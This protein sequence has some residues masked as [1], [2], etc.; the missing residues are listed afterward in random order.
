M[1]VRHGQ[2]VTLG[3]A[4]KKDDNVCVPRI[5]P[6]D[7][8]QKGGKRELGWFLRRAKGVNWPLEFVA[9]PN[10]LSPKGAMTA[11]YLPKG[12]VTR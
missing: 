7:W 12:E 1:A 3:F 6:V 11:P 2:S 5:L 4:Q 8:G 9:A 10:L